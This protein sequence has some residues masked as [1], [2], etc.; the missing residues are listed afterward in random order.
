MK[1][2]KRVQKAVEYVLEKLKNK[3]LAKFLLSTLIAFFQVFYILLRYKYINSEIPFWFTR[4]WGDFQLAPKMTLFLVPLISLGVT[5]LG[6]LFVLINNLYIK[7][8]DEVVWFVVGFCNLVLSYSVFRIIQVS[9]IAYKPFIS[10]LYVSLFPSFVVAFLGVYILTPFFIEFAQRKK[11]VTNPS[12][13]KH[14]GMILE[15]PSARGGGLV[16]G[17]VFLA[18]S[19]VFVGINKNFSGLYLSVLMVSVLGILDD[20]QNT[21]PKSGF[22]FLENPL[23]RLILLFA[24]VLPVIFS[25]VLI[26]TVSN[27]FGGMINLDIIRFGF[28]G[29]EISLIPVILT[30]IW[31]VWFM[32]VL[33]WS[34]GIDGQY[35]GIVGIASVLV[36][37]L[38][39]RFEVLEPYHTQIATLAAISAGAAFGTVKFNWYPSKIMWGFGAMTVGLVVASL[40]IYARARITA[41]VLI[42]LIPFLDAA[43]TVVR[44]LLKGK[45]PFKGD[46]GHLHH[47]LME[48]G[49]GVRRIALFYWVA[50]ALFGL[51]GLLSSEV[52]VFKVG[53][54]IA[55]FVGFMIVLL[56]VRVLRDKVETLTD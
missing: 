33:S 45:N 14:P 46:R 40:A 20:Y 51:V 54:F 3:T 17:L 23:L 7:F 42:I 35:S 16:Y 53:F 41:S 2:D 19:L 29:R 18:A 26:R 34:N 38:A 24:S 1:F 50:T 9:S 39:L 32:N 4:I 12:V 25:G 11:M 22:S 36:A 8:V 10:P 44:R 21:H 43:V 31:V 49:W 27:P 55:G 5:L 48:R 28:L 52:H 37:L 15:N 56:N 6:L 30:T 13:H 47:V